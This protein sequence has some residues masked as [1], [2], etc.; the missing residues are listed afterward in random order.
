MET[1]ARAAAKETETKALKSALGIDP[2]YVA[3]SAFDRE[4]QQKKRDERQEQREDERQ[5]HRDRRRLFFA[6]CKS[7][8]PRR[9]RRPAE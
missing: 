4:L 2:G 6:S 5:E 3:G 9:E 8:P 1:H 7:A